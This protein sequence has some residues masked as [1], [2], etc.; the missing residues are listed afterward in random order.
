MKEM[1]IRRKLASAIAMASI[2]HEE[3]SDKGG[4]AYI[5]HPLRVMG[6]MENDLD[7]IVAVLHDVA[8]DCPE[9]PLENLRKAFG[10]E[11]GDA[12]DALTKRDGEAYDDYLSR[13][14]ANPRAARVKMADLEDNS[15]LLRLGRKPSLAD[16][17]RS[18]KYNGA[19][20]RLS[21]SL[22]HPEPSS[23]S[24]AGES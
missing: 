2:A 4:A 21:R 17:E 6:R 10:D 23:F 15:D 3:Q 13:V 7:R 11:I 1:S 22:I 16:L 5:L 12:L 19:L 14:E 8:E 18:A 9:F 24:M 20:A